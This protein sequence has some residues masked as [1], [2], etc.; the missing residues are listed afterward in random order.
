MKEW[1]KNDWQGKRKEQV[2]YSAKVLFFASI[3]FILLIIISTI[4]TFFK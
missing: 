3:G 4:S 2:D 1:N